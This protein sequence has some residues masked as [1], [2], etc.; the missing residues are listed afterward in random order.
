MLVPILLLD[1]FL[2]IY[3]HVCFPLYGLPLVKRKE[4]LLLDRWRIQE[5]A[6]YDRINCLYCEYA[7]GLLQYAVAIAGATERYWC[8][9]K[10]QD[11]K[12]FKA[13]AHQKDFV[14]YAAAKRW[15]DARKRQA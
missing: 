3:H 5:L 15:R 10:H 2:E 12:G 14:P 8:G 7:N 9:I 11:V 13:P 4:Y 6:W 1:I